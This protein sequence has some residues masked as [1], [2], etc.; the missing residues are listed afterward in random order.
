[1]KQIQLNITLIFIYKI[2]IGFSNPKES[3][4]ILNRQPIPNTF[5]ENFF[6]S[7]GIILQHVDEN[8]WDG[9]DSLGDKP[10]GNYTRG[11][12]FFVIAG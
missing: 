2:G 8:I 1:M 7:G 5:D 9:F 12:P 4:L 11:G 3:L 10:K 6:N